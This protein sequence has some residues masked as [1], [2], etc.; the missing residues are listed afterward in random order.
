M[1]SELFLAT[2]LALPVSMAKHQGSQKLNISVFK[3]LSTVYHIDKSK[4]NIK[5]RVYIIGG[6]RRVVD[7]FR[8]GNMEAWQISSFPISRYTVIASP[9][10][11]PLLKESATIVIY[12]L[13]PSIDRWYCMSMF[14]A[15][16]NTLSRDGFFAFPSA[17]APAFSDIAKHRQWNKLP[18]RWAGM[19]IWQK[20]ESTYRS[21]ISQFK[22]VSESA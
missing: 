19:E 9:L 2:A 17:I 12:L 11:I 22:V 14:S 13:T 10:S 1:I 20:N 3:F 5:D 7:A 16:A 6:D 21:K 4:Q 8:S 18:F 15:A